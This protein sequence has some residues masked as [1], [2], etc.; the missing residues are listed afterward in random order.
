MNIGLQYIRYINEYILKLQIHQH[1][2]GNWHL[3]YGGQERIINNPNMDEKRNEFEERDANTTIH[4]EGL[5]F[6]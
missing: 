6:I 2:L 5:P 3:Y 1:N 4:I